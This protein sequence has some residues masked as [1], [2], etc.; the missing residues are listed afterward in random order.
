MVEASGKPGPGE[1]MKLH[2]SERQVQVCCLV[3]ADASSKEISRDLRISVKT[4]EKHMADAAVRIQQ[5]HPH[6]SG[7]ARRIIRGF[8]V[9]CYGVALFQ[10][11]LRAA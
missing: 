4:V 2:L 3:A 6:L 9:E 7:S 8:Y 11:T 1:R 5:V 10:D